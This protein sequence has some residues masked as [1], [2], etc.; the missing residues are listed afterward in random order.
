MTTHACTIRI[1]VKTSRAGLFPSHKA[2][3]IFLKAV[4]PI[5]TEW[6]VLSE[7]R[8]KWRYWV[9]GLRAHGQ[10]HVEFQGCLKN[11]YPKGAIA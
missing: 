3:Q 8:A 5:I 9:T 1:S 7:I 10:G 2:F 4:N 6:L 11:P